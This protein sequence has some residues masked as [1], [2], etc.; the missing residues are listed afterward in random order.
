MTCV[1]QMIPTWYSTCDLLMDVSGVPQLIAYVKYYT[2]YMT[3]PI[4][5]M[6][7]YENRLLQQGSDGLVDLG[8]VKLKIRQKVTYLDV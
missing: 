8:K 4:F 7:M 2:Q 3:N 6:K 1:C 5:T